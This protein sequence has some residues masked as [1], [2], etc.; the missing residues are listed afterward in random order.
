[1]RSLEATIAASDFTKA[2]GSMGYT[3]YAGPN[4]FGDGLVPLGS[5][6]HLVVQVFPDGAPQL[7]GYQSGYSDRYASWR[8]GCQEGNRWAFDLTGKSGRPVPDSAAIRADT[9]R[10]LRQMLEGPQQAQAEVELPELQLEFKIADLAVPAK[11]PALADDL[12]RV[13]ASRHQ[14]AVLTAPFAGTFVEVQEVQEDPDY[15]YV[16]LAG[17]NNQR[18]SVLVPAA[19]APACELGQAIQA[20]QPLVQV[21]EAVSE[22]ILERLGWWNVQ[23]ISKN[24]CFARLPLVYCRELLARGTLPTMVFE[25]IRKILG[26]EGPEIASEVRTLLGL[27]RPLADFDRTDQQVVLQTAK[28]ILGSNMRYTTGPDILNA[29][30]GGPLWLSRMPL[31]Q[32]WAVRERKEMQFRKELFFADFGSLKS[33]F[34]RALTAHNSPRVAAQQEYAVLEAA[35]KTLQTDGI[36]AAA[37]LLEAGHGQPNAVGMLRLL[38]NYGTE[39]AAEAYLTSRQQAVQN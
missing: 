7:R 15:V 30:D 37:N 9:L 19:A 10:V 35:V 36:T 20:G 13:R 38:G 3:V 2:R 31:V 28:Q 29:M 4:G 32:T 27:T 23:Q 25:D 39:K 22:P 26:T 33:E 8:V 18:H 34:R 21:T 16:V 11:S 17:D 24:G 5:L 12:R 1:M 14:L 6:T